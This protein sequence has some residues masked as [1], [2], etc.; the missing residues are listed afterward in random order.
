ML[1]AIQNVD[2]Q[3]LDFIQNNMRSEWLD[4]I[5]VFFSFLG[6]GGLIWIV[7]AVL[8]LGFRKYRKTGLTMGF[9]L[10]IGL[11]VGNLILKNLVARARPCDVQP[12]VD[13]LIARP[14]DYSFPSGHTLSSF[15]C[16]IVLFCNKKSWGVP[17]LILA[18]LIAFSRMYLYVH[19]PTDILSGLLI[20][21]GSAVLAMALWKS[22]SLQTVEE[23]FCR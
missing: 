17:A 15:E 4:K 3:I 9:A 5:M 21:I 10:L 13:M 20:G 18:S 22:K 8:L 6:N 23:R 2:Q 12:I 7:L 11:F 14:S 1:E 19:Y 16:A